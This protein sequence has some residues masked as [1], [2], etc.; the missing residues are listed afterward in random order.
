[1]ISFNYKG[2]E[3]YY[4]RNTQGDIIGLYNTTGTKVV[5]YTYD[6]WG[7]QIAIVEWWTIPANAACS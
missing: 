7:K 1:M 3:Y 6:S 2:K 5:T 4:I